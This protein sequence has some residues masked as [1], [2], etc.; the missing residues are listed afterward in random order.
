MLQI[1]VLVLAFKNSVTNFAFLFSLYKNTNKH[2]KI[3]LIFVF[4]LYK[5]TNCYTLKMIVFRLEKNLFRIYIIT[6]DLKKKKKKKTLL[7]IYIFNNLDSSFFHT[8]QCV[9]LWFLFLLF[10]S[11]WL[12]KSILVSAFSFHLA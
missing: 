5:G 10:Y 9:A 6:L 7:L 8:D 1:F 12:L 3:L 11:S 2:R 4:S